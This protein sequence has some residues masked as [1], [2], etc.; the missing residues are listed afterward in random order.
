[1]EYL[2]VL[3]VVVMEHHVRHMSK[4]VSDYM[5]SVAPA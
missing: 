1:M 2:P 3:V 4:I 5:S